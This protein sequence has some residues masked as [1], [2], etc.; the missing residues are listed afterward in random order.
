MTLGD[1]SIVLMAAALATTGGIGK[2]QD[3]PWTIPVDT[4]YLHEITTKA[5]NASTTTTATTSSVTD[6]QW[7]NVVVHG[8]LSWESIPMKSIPMPQRFNIVISRNPS[9][10]IASYP[11]AS[12]VTSIHDAVD[13]AKQLVQNTQ[14]RVFVL[15]GGQ[16]YG[17]AMKLCTHILLTRVHDAKQSIVCDAFMP[18][19]DTSLFVQASHSELEG[20]VQQPVPQGRQVCGDLEYEFLLYVRS[21]SLSP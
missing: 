4:Q 14:G 3:L 19:V 21:T 15:G 16:I 17:Q 10:K 13:Q 2:G 20:F 7:H 5:Y 12:L 8:R 18:P 9:Y 6:R 11:N 1:T